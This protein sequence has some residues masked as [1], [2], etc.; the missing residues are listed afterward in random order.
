MISCLTATNS[1]TIHNAHSHSHS[2]F[3]S[4]SRTLSLLL[5]LRTVRATAGGDC[6]FRVLAYGVYGNQEMHAYIR[7]LVV[8]K[9]REMD[10]E[11]FPNQD[12]ES[13]CNKMAQKGKYCDG[14]R[15]MLAAC[16]ALNVNLHVFGSTGEHD[17]T[18]CPSEKV[19]LTNDV[20]IAH[21]DHGNMNDHFKGVEPK[22]RE[23]GGE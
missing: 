17:R 9:L 5:F 1:R 14:Q 16:R 3:H 21:Y 20:L 8:E 7:H 11:F 12:R 10:P 22:A 6:F 2:H 23:E 15:E 4:L 13:Y 18:F 19:G